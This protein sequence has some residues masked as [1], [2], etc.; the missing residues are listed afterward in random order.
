M[1]L[2]Q[3]PVEV[4]VVN[5]LVSHQEALLAKFHRILVEPVGQSVGKYHPGICI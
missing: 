2:D 3:S 1:R 5:K 4:E